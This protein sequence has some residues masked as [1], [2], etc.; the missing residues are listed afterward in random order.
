MLASEYLFSLK[1]SSFF[2]QLDPLALKQ[3]RKT[4]NS[5]YLHDKRDLLPVISN[6]EFIFVLSGKIHLYYEKTNQER[7]LIGSAQ[8]GETLLFQ[9]FFEIW[10]QKLQM[11]TAADTTL[12]TIPIEL[13]KHLIAEN[14][15][16]QMKMI[17]SLQRNIEYSY[18]LISS[19]MNSFP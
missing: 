11:E 9:S 8:S 12:L 1:S 3:I 14:Q 13:M 7:M 15:V 4:A 18:Q 6:R 16:L 10:N 5:L 2:R 17:Q 19:Q